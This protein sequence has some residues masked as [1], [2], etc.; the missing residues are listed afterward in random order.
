MVLVYPVRFRRL[1]TSNNPTEDKT[2]SSNNPTKE[3]LRGLLSRVEWGSRCS[4]KTIGV[5]V[6]V[7][8]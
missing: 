6:V 4:Q 3:K 5:C 7:V 2:D 8:G 1:A